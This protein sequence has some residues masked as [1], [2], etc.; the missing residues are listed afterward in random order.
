MAAALPAE[1]REVEKLLRGYVANVCYTII[2]EPFRGWVESVMEGRNKKIEAER[3]LL[4]EMDPAIAK[5]FHHSNDVSGKL[6][7]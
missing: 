6:K 5:I 7:L 2:G 1:P 3:N 4:I